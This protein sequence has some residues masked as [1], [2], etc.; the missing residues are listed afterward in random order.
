[1]AEF[2]QTTQ[3]WF[4]WI[5]V[6]GS[7]ISFIWLSYV[8]PEFIELFE[9]F[10]SDLPGITKLV[11]NIH[12]NFYLLAIPGFIGNILI[13]LKKQLAGWWLV[14]FSGVMAITL[15]PLTIIA[16]YLPI[17]QMSEVVVQ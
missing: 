5:T 12:D 7:L 16:M 17:F 10:G 14:G 2:K 4:A 13:H 6:L 1:M 8:V 15:I 11:I 9:E 3:L